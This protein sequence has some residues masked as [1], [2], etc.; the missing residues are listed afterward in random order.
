M[1]ARF[2]EIGCGKLGRSGSHFHG[3]GDDVVNVAVVAEQAFVRYR[4]HRVLEKAFSDR[5]IDRDSVG[6]GAREVARFQIGGRLA[7]K[8]CGSIDGIVADAAWNALGAHRADESIARDA[9]CGFIDE[10]NERVDNFARDAWIARDR[11]NP[12]DSAESF[13]QAGGSA[14]L[15]FDLLGKA[16]E[17]REQNSALPFRHPVVRAHQWPFESVAG[18]ATSAIDERLAS[19][20]EVG[21]VGRDHSTFAGGHGLGGLKTKA[22]ESAMST[23]AA[24]APSSTRDVG[25]ILD[26]RNGMRARN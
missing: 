5:A 15:A 8:Q 11:G 7:R 17:L 23:D 3:R 25:A 9:E 19:L 4:G 18:A 22:S 24:L 14:A 12:L 13:A 26:E 10:K 1:L 6:A 21:V 20:L 16:R 2:F